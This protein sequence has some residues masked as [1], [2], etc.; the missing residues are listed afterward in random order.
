MSASVTRLPTRVPEGEQGD[1]ALVRLVQSLPHGSD[2]RDAACEEL[3]ARY[4]SLVPRAPSATG[5]AP[6]RRKS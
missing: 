2:T 1:Q 6:S 4:Q 5:R 3:V